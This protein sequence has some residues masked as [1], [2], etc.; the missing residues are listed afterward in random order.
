MKKKG[1]GRGLDALFG[2]SEKEYG[3]AQAQVSAK[4]LEVGESA[5][6]ELPVANIVA[7][8]DQPRKSFTDI[9]M[10][11][12][13]SSV[14][15]HGVITPIIVVPQGENYMIIAGERRW[16]ASQKAGLKKIPAVVREYSPQ[17]IKE[18]SL[19]ENLQREDLNPIE[20]ANAMKQLMDEFNLTQEGVADRL[21]K[22]RAS[23]ANTLRLLSL[24]SPVI[25]LVA[26]TRL[27]EGHARCLAGLKISEAEQFSLASE[28]TDNKM[29]VRDFEKRVKDYFIPPE[30]STPS[31]PKTPAAPQSLEMRDLTDRMRRIFGT[32]VVA[33]GS[34]TKGKLVIEY[35]N[36]DDLDRVV[37]ILEILE[38]I[39]G[40]N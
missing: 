4:D 38:G 10:S 32:K 8:P 19:I 33:M 5:A 35:Y 16:R 39:K 2:N 36:T 13:V 6:T 14:R 23:V 37:D 3:N 31:A 40:N 28:A 29:T 21:G 9:A 7:N 25:D 12:L 22:S 26:T 11:D 17:Q 18:L 27:S 15:I 34:D 24:T 1:L 30:P 20:T